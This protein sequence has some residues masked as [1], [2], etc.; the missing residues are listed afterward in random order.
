MARE[1]YQ[2]REGV[3]HQPTYR[4]ALGS[5]D[6]AR[7]LYLLGPRH[8][9]ELLVDRQ[10]QELERATVGLLDGSVAYQNDGSETVFGENLKLYWWLLAPAAAPAVAPTALAKVAGSGIRRY[11][12]YRCHGC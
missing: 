3:G 9:V 4:H 11:R 6:C 1:T 7:G 5:G 8:A 10:R 2:A 12:R